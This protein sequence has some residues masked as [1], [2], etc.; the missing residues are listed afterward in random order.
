MKYTSAELS[1][2]LKKLRSLRAMLLDKEIKTSVFHCAVGENAEEL[3]PAYDYQATQ[4]ELDRLNDSILAI[5]HALNVFN[6]T[7]EVEGLTIDRILIRL[8]MLQEK[9]AKLETMA[10][11]LERERVSYYRS[12]GDIID[13]EVRNY[14][15]EQ[16]MANLAEVSEEIS[17]LQMALDKVNMTELIEVDI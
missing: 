7:T 17:R 9:R 14:D 8:P 10:G 2:E 11:R 16:V 13:Y 15:P 3:R 5:R 4:D 12:T 1:K 6:A